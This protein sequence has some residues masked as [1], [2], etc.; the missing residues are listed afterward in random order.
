[1]NQKSENLFLFLSAA[2]N[3]S[4]P[5]FRGGRFIFFRIFPC[6]PE[7]P[8]V[9]PSSAH[10]GCL[11]PPTEPPLPGLPPFHAPPS[12][13]LLHPVGVEPNRRPTPFISP[14]SNGRPLASTPI[15]GMS[16]KH[17]QPFPSPH[18]L[19]S[20]P[21]PLWPYK[22]CHRLSHSPPHPKPLRPS[23]LPA[24][25]LLSS[26]ANRRRH[27]LTVAGLPPAPHRPSSPTVGTAE[28]SSSFSPTAGELPLTGA[29]PSPCSGEPFGRR[30][31]WSTVDP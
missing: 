3:Q 8:T 12:V 17:R 18:C 19:R 23:P 26:R 1:L 30:W 25:S 5:K 6:R 10:R 28:V 11:P 21:S 13:A 27:H 29:A 16:M 20:P 22:R 2:R 9:R 15:T 24:L 7:Y 4:G 14:S 31:P